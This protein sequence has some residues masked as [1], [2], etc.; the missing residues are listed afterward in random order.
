[1]AEITL[2][3]KDGKHGSKATN[4]SK[5]SERQLI[6][7]MNKLKEFERAILAEYEKRKKIDGGN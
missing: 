4:F 6:A 5:M 2:D 7:I 3:P 1:M